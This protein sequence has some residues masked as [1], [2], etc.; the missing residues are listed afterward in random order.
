MTNVDP[1]GL[2][3]FNVNTSASRSDEPSA[4]VAGIITV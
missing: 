4:A 2:L 3:C 1:S